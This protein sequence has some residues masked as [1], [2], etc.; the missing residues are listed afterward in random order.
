MLIVIVCC[1]NKYNKSFIF[2]PELQNDTYCILIFIISNKKFINISQLID[3]NSKTFWNS[4]FP[5]NKR[6]KKTQ[7]LFGWVLKVASSY[8]P[9]VKT[10]VPSAQSGLTSLFGM[11]RGGP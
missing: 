5:K 11:G 2:T 9:T 6:H 10:A 1:Y 7:P 8:S 3:F 4:N